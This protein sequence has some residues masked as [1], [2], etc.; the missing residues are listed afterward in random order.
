MVYVSTGVDEYEKSGKYFDCQ[1]SV[2]SLC[3][4]FLV[5]LLASLVTRYMLCYNSHSS[6]IKGIMRIITVH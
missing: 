6:G 5:T 1:L 2:S 3:I 4:C